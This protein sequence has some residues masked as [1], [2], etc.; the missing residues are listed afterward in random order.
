[1]SN[2]TDLYY[3]YLSVQ[4][5]FLLLRFPDRIVRDERGNPT[6][7]PVYR[8]DGSKAFAWGFRDKERTEEYVHEEYNGT[9]L[10]YLE[11]NVQQFSKSVAYRIRLDRESGEL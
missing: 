11:K 10:T 3:S 9:E 2:P 5:A 1:M 8:D 6:L 4:A 7:F